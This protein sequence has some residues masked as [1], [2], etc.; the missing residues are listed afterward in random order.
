MLFK[1]KI[2]KKTYDPGI[3]E[4][5]IRTSICTGEKVAG[6]CDLTSGRFEEVMLINSEKDL[7]EFIDTYGITGKIRKIY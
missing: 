7:Q 5:A 6:F 3:K 2:E 4:P 1:R